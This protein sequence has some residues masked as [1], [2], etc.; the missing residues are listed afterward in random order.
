MRG[1]VMRT[2]RWAIRVLILAACAGAPPS[3]AVHASTSR[4]PS[5]WLAA[6]SR[7]RLRGGAED[8]R[9]TPRRGNAQSAL[10]EGQLVGSSEHAAPVVRDDGTWGQG[11]LFLTEARHAAKQ[12][13]QHGKLLLV[14]I[15]SEDGDE[16]GGGAA[17]VWSDPAV[18]I[19]ASCEVV[20]LVVF[21]DTSEHR[22]LQAAHGEA[23]SLPALYAVS[24]S[25][26]LVRRHTGPLTVDRVLTHIDLALGALHKGE[27]TAAQIQ[28]LREAH[29]RAQA[30]PG[31]PPAQHHQKG[32]GPAGGLV[33]T[34]PS[35]HQVPVSIA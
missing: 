33:Q 13:K 12:A 29:G 2:G 22:W 32:S 30:P 18:Q 16:T 27:A 28:Q 20:C 7:L 1:E 34:G 26:T 14:Y 10:S 31:A 11:G 9:G 19:A 24:P 15:P 25:G 35:R 21:A 8:T 23:A 6:C 5:S 3:C 4:A 17:D